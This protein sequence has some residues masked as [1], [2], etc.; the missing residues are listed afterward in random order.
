MD[1]DAVFDVDGIVTAVAGNG[2]WMTDPVP[3]GVDATSDGIFVFRGGEP[4]PAVGDHVVVDGTVDE[5]RPGGSGGFENLTTTEIV[6]FSPLE[7]LVDRQRSADVVI[8]VD[9]V[10]PTAVIED[11]ATTSVEAAGVLFDPEEDGLDFWESLEGMRARGRRCGRR[12][13]PH[14]ASARSPSS[15]SSRRAPVFALRVV[16]SSCAT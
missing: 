2:F 9:R 16:G 3:D 14:W 7:T 4:K 6:S 12:R 13:A 15:A 1:G 11:D 8:G 10:P 5:F